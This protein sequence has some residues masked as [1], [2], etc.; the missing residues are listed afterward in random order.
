M[1]KYLI[2]YLIFWLPALLVSY[3]FAGGGLMADIP[4]WFFA[5]FMLFGWSVNTGMA[6]YHF[7][8]GALSALLAYGGFNTLVIVT[9]YTTDY[10]QGLH[11]FMR[12]VGGIFSFQPL[13]ILVR[14]L[15]PITSAA[16]PWEFI[17]L[18]VLL[19]CCLLGYLVGVVQRRVRPNPYSPRI[20]H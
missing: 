20:R 14:N 7:P 1:K 15:K 4:Q 19:V 13:D 17:V 11:I 18:C 16:L 10:R 5:F 8:R 2:R 12:K 3:L 9:L 6:A